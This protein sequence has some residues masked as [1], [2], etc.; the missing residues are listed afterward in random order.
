MHC[1]STNA[2][3]MMSF[4]VETHTPGLHSGLPA[5]APASAPAST[6]DYPYSSDSDSTDSETFADSKKMDVLPK[7]RSSSPPPLKAPKK[8]NKSE[9]PKIK[10][11]V[12]KAPKTPKEVKAAPAPPPAV[13]MPGPSLNIT[14]VD[15]PKKEKKVKAPAVVADGAAPSAPAE[16]KKRAPS[17]YNKFVSEKMKQGLSMVAVAALWKESKAA[18]GGA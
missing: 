5:A 18:G 10:S 13:T 3:R 11:E 17:A 15:A 14:E 4:L 8:A 16:K 1:N 2:R 6:Q 7:R 9:K 12:K